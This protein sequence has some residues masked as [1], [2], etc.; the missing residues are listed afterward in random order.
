MRDPKRFLP[1]FNAVA[2]GS[3]PNDDNGHGTHVTGIIA[4]EHGDRIGTAGL[5]RRCK[6]YV[7]KVFDS[8]GFGSTML[9]YQAIRRAISYARARGWRLII[10][11]SGG[12]PADPLYEDIGDVVTR[13]GALLVA[14]A[15]NESGPVRFPAALST[16]SDGSIW[17]ANVCAVGATDKSDEIASFSN[18][19]PQINVAA[20]G[21]DIISALPYPVNGE[22]KYGL[23]SGTSMATPY[24]SGV[25][26]WIWTKERTWNAG[27]VREQ[28][29]QTCVD[30]G[31]AGRDPNYG[32]GRID[33][34]KAV[35]FM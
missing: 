5:N 21:V 14:A 2:P 24:V 1:E 19:G 33:A 6:V 7:G 25:A 17:Y 13:G 20:P 4:A 30:L 32:F 34:Y 8:A 27:H 28:L 31:P 15:G 23:L 9:L 10:N 35:R 18:F 12:G 29:E 16:K 22:P 3:S 26:S 11:Y